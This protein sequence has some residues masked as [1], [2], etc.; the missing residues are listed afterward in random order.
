MMDKI[1]KILMPMADVLTK[2]RVLIA[3]RDGF[4]IT[5]PLL[6]VGSIFLL[7]ANFPIPGWEEAIATVLGSGW[8][9][10]FKAVSRASFNCTGLL[11]ALGTGYA[12]A[13]ELDVD[14]I[15]GAAVSLVAY[16]ILMPTIHPAL[17]ADGAVIEGA[18]S[19]AG[20]S[21]DYIG[22]D[23][24]FMALICSILG[25]WLFATI[26]KKGWTIKLP[27]SVPPAVSDSFAALI[28][29]AIVMGA[30]FLIRIA[31]SFTEFGYF[32][33]F[34]VSI[35]QT[36]LEGLGDTLG[37]NVLYTFMC[38]FLWFF[39]I[40]GP[41]VCNSVFFIGNVLTA[42]QLI[43]FEAGQP[44]PY[45]FTNPFSNFFC[46]FGGGGSTLSLVILMV[47]VCKSE[48]ITKL[49]KLSLIP[50]I[51]GINEPIIF[52][53]PIVLNPVIAIP[54]IVVPTMNLVLSYFATLWGIIPK[55]TGVNLPW[56]T[57][58]GF[59]G[60]LSTGSWRASV[61]QFFL[62]FL[63]IMIYYPFI[64]TLDKK[65]LLEE[66]AAKENESEEDDIS[67]DDLDL[68]DL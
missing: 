57:P 67:F 17:D 34:V 35:L 33:N 11:T 63:G 53:L 15:Q 22:P 23:G 41:A 31:F 66:Q 14:R 44:L 60:Y 59:S 62:L 43:A 27:K 48:R 4:L 49:G 65:Y 42:K 1:E 8:T 30:A 25:V 56:T 10:W 47:T 36:P 46:N 61:W 24:I 5:T 55:T 9:D 37:A 50:G 6:I 45:I 40:N 51:F 28:P 3:I 54:F 16:F 18:Q 29:T 39:G 58:I 52:G 7:I 19:F 38:S 2:N 13:R 12:M 26:Y 64:K 21:F 20:L 32:Q 68:E